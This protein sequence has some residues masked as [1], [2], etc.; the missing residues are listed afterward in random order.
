ML[1]KRSLRAALLAGSVI[2][3]ACGPKTPNPDLQIRQAVAQT[4]AAIPDST[5]QP[6]PTP[7]PSPTALNLTGLF[8]EYKFCIS[9]PP[10]MAFFDVSAQQNPGAPS[11]YTQGIMAS[12]SATLFIQIMWQI[13]PGA[14]DPTFLLDLIVDDSFDIAAG[15]RATKQSGSVNALYTPITST[16]SPVLPFGAAAAWVC[17][18]RVFAWKVYTPDASSPEGL[19]DD[20]AFRFVCQ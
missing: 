9:H 2:L 6:F 4:M 15:S 7:F 12:Y 13:A 20:A 18:D 1:T 16:A 5:R 19:F 8:C 11:T 3:A 17:L 10:D 14:S